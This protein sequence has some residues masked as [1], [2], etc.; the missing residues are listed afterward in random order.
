MYATIGTPTMHPRQNTIAKII[1]TIGKTME[2]FLDASDP[3]KVYA[4]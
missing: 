2:D 1:R 4:I 3:P